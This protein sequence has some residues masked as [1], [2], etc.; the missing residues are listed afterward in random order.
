MA[1]IDIPKKVQRILDKKKEKS[2]E[3][4]N[5]N[6]RVIKQSFLI[7]CEG[8]NTE[9]DYFNEFKLGAAKVESIGEGKN[10]VSLVNSA[11]QIKRKYLKKG[12][13]FDQYWVVFDK[14]DFNAQDFNNAILMAEADGFKVAYSNQA[15]EF[16]Y[17]LHFN[18]HQGQIDRGTYAQTLSDYL[19][20][21]YLKESAISE[22]MFY[23][24]FPKVE[25]AIRNA[26]AVYDSFGNLHANPAGEESSTTVY[27]LVEE[28]IKYLK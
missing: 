3:R 27:K 10:T 26:K 2:I 1:S 15:F 8:E 4:F 19:G 24:T 22:K 5:N 14:D 28:L 23:E 11:I 6:T 18:L 17:L 21:D 20:F 7:I 12:E 9:P 13:Q 16:W 25:D